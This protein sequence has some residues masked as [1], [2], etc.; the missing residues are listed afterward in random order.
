MNDKNDKNLPRNGLNIRK[1]D[2]CAKKKRPQGMGD[3]PHT[4][5]RQQGKKL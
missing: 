4:I 3:T 5:G 1:N 2:L